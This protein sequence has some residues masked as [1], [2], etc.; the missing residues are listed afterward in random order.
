MKNIIEPLSTTIYVTTRF[1]AFHR[2]VDAP[3]EVSFLREYHRHLFHVRL[4]LRVAHKNREL[5]FFMVQKVLVDFVR[6]H[7]EGEYFPHSCEDLAQ[8]IA[9]HISV[10]YGQGVVAA[11]EVSEDGENGAVLTFGVGKEN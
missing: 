4:S 8:F 9:N 5:E 1:A 3:P 6:E 10:R 7:F 11:V 2:W